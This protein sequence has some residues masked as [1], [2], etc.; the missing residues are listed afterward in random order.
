MR[1]VIVGKIVESLTLGGRFEP[2]EIERCDDGATKR[3][4]RSVGDPFAA[5]SVQFQSGA[6]TLSPGLRP[7]VL[8]P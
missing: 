3:A 7:G 1:V 4:L 6:G 5:V 8:L 2:A